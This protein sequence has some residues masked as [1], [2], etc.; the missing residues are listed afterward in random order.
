M[1][2][3]W[4][5]DWSR[6]KNIRKLIT[7]LLQPT[8]NTQKISSIHTDP[9][10]LCII[11]F[12]QQ[13]HNTCSCMQPKSNYLCICA[14]IKSYL[15]LF[16]TNLLSRPQYKSISAFTTYPRSIGLTISLI[17]LIETEPKLAGG[18]PTLQ[19]EIMATL[20]GVLIRCA[21]LE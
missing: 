6:K 13:V 3:I 17:P 19:W 12:Q 14:S 16:T 5:Q 4:E 20:S 10:S 15:R 11:T 9:N 18:F 8:V 21:A 1:N 2:G 7:R